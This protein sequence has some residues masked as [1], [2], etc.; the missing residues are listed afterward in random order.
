MPPRPHA[1]LL[2]PS[3]LGLL[4]YDVLEDAVFLGPGRKGGLRANPTPFQ[5]A[6]VALARKEDGYVAR[7]LPGETAPEEPTDTGE[8]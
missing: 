8:D 3:A 1:H 4:E 2:L 6:T 5:G 7:P